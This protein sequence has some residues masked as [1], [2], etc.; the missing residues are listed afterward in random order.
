MGTRCP[1]VHCLFPT[2]DPAGGN[3]KMEILHKGHELVADH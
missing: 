1:G 2:E 3:F